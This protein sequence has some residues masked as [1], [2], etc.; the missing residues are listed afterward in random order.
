M[1]IN[2]LNSQHSHLIALTA[3]ALVHGSIAAWSM[4]P[5]N[6]VVI[7]QQAIHVSFVAPSASEK[8]SESASHK[9]IALN[10][11]SENAL[12]QKKNDKVEKAESKT[13]KNKLAGKETSG[14]VDPNA[15]ATKSAE[16]D[17]V[18]DAAYLNNPAPSYPQAAK[19]KGIQGKVMV[20]VTVKPDGTP[21]AVQVCHSSGSNIL[22]DAALEA[23]RQWKFIPAR[24]GGEF[25]QANVVVPVDFK[26][27]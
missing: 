2:F 3:A 24:R 20:N 13:E 5:S 8:K 23:V 17:P 7:S 10:V 16:T 19:R 27:I 14:R 25:V 11:E 1:K 15:T 21:A 26:M 22:D 6:P 18:F 12:K 4:M 9:K